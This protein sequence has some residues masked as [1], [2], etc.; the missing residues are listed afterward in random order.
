[1][2]TKNVGILGENIAARYLI[3]SD[4]NLIIRNYKD[5]F[6][7]IDI[8]GKDNKGELVFVEVKSGSKSGYFMPEDHLTWQKLKRVN[9]ISE[10]FVGGHQ[11]LINEER[12][13][14]IDLIVV[15]IKDN[16]RYDLR[17]YKNI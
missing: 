13:W 5:G 2:N 7:E 16:G 15:V 17:H 14:R 12:G 1:M 4:Y 11:L 3:K 6:D 10:K 9:R 8:I